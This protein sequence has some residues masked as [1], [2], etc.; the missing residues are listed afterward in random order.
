MSFLKVRRR[1]GEFAFNSRA[2]GP[3]TVDKAAYLKGR[4]TTSSR[5]C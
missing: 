5:A 2:E 4:R 1:V 3:T